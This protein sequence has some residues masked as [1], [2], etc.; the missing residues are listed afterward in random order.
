[1]GEDRVFVNNGGTPP[2]TE[3]PG[4]I[5][6]TGISVGFVQLSSFSSSNVAPPPPPET[7]APYTKKSEESNSVMGMMDLLVKDLDKEMTEAETGEKVSQED[8][9]KTMAD[10]AEKRAQD[11]K[12]LND[13]E[14]AKADL[15]SSLEESVD[16]Q[17]STSKELMATMQYIAELHAECDWLLQYF[18]VRKQAR[19]DEIDSLNRAKAVLSGADFAL[20]Q[21]RARS[22][23]ARDH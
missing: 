18:D 8:Y 6:G 22:F 15:E 9:E 17:A 13:R 4:G 7:M 19:A 12:S 20:L 1:M 16:E 10:S 11:A 2:P 5:A 21:T 14:A 3:A 23:L